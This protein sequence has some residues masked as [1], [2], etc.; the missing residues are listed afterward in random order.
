M[1]VGLNTQNF[2]RHPGRDRSINR[3]YFRRE[4]WAR[5]PEHFYDRQGRGAAGLCC[6]EFFGVGENIAST[7][8]EFRRELLAQLAERA[9]RG[10]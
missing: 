2:C 10:A 9:A 5:H 3:Q 8:R 6:W 4:D 7:G 1:D